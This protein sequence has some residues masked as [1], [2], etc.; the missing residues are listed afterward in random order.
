MK[1][2][3]LI[4]YHEAHLRDMTIHSSSNSKASGT[5]IGFVEEG[6]NGGIEHLKKLGVNAVQFLPLWDF[7][8]FEIP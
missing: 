5:Y 3:D 6:Q 2:E 7:A 1:S 8:N 4:I